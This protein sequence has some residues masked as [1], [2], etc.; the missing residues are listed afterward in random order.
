M[1]NI[2]VVFRNRKDAS[3]IRNLLARKGHNVVAACTSGTAVMQYLDRLEGSDGLIV[4]GARY[5]DMT[6]ADLLAELPDTFQM[7]VMASQ[8]VL[9]TIY[10]SNVIKVSMPV[11]AYDLLMALDG[12]ERSILR[13]RR[14]RRL[15]PRTRSSEDLAV[16]EYAK[17]VIMEQ[18]NMSEEQA[19]RYLQKTSMNN[20]T[21]MAETA[22]MII[23][24]FTRDTH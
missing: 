13:S 17:N 2:I 11:K 3:V 1:V 6:Y 23:E 5:E 16:I 10:E 14:R 19:H 20:G 9:S 8:A 22:Q 24:L 21:G 7:M 4:S 15:K 18:K 12:V